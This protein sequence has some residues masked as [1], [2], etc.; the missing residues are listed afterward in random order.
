MDG[1]KGTEETVLGV[2]ESIV[3]ISEGWILMTST[4]LS[5]DT[6][7]IV[8]G[9]LSVFLQ[10][11]TAVSYSVEISVPQISQVT[12]SLSGSSVAQSEAVWNSVAVGVP[13]Y[14]SA[15]SNVV[16][17]TSAVSYSDSDGIVGNEAKEYDGL[18]AVAYS[19]RE[20]GAG[21]S[22]MLSS[23]PSLM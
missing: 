2:L 8:L 21:S 14:G 11:H 1:V 3:G 9:A 4:S 16:E 20:E 19:E 6:D 18:L 12:Y 22:G 23:V 5:M 10:L 7:S 17:Q 15:V 13:R